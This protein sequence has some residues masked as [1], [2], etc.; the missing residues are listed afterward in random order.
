MELLFT[1]IVAHY[2]GDFPLQGDFL[3]E[4]KGKFDYLLFSHA[5]IWTGVICAALGYFHVLAW[6]KVGFL[7]FGHM[8]IDR[9]KARKE[10][11]TNALTKDLWIDQAL[12]V[13]Q[14]LTVAVL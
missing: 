6:W 14:I 3:G 4:M 7:L 9:W 8:T 5:V 2:I 1:L 10:D 11:K 13:V 12:H